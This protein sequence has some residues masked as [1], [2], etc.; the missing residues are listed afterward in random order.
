MIGR[1][2]ALTSVFYAFMLAYRAELI[3]WALA[4][5]M[6]FIM[7]GAWMQAAEVH[8][9]ALTPDDF[10][11]YFLTLFIVRQLTAVWVIWDVEQDV[12]RGRLARSLLMPFP[13]SARY[14]LSH[15]ADRLARGPFLV[16]LVVLF[17]AMRPQTFFV[18]TWD[19]ALLFVV[20]VVCALAL[21]FLIQFT[22]AMLAFWT[23]RAS[24]LEGI[25]SLVYVFC[26]GVIA[27]LSLFPD[28]VRDVLEVLPFALLLHFP[29]AVLLGLDVDVARSFALLLAWGAL[30]FVA[31]RLLWRA[32]LRRFTSMGA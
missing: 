27:P 22:L 29:T 5:S 9:L 18:P 31:N 7:M 16:G 26:S 21:R 10:A 23:E 6:P 17:L 32:G 28:A 1:V 3:L 14:V 13:V 11:R 8:A 20:T 2:L 24:A 15:V 4:S 30:F 25:F 19:R 12:V